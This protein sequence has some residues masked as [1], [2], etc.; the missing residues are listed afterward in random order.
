[1]DGVGR[2]VLDFDAV[3]VSSTESDTEGDIGCDD[4]RDAVGSSV[5]DQEALAVSSDRDADVVCST[6]GDRLRVS[7]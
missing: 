3:E 2:G 7:T 6:E 5:K 1:M 4:E